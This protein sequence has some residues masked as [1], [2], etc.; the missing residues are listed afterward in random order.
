MVDHDPQ[1]LS[2]EANFRTVAA[3]RRACAWLYENDNGVV[4]PHFD[5]LDLEMQ[6]LMTAGARFALMHCDADA[7]L[8][9]QLNG[10]RIRMP[11]Q[12]VT[13]N[14]SSVWMGPGGLE[15]VESASSLAILQ[16]VVSP[17]SLLI[18]VGCGH[19][20]RSLA[21]AQATGCRTVAYDRSMA[22]VRMLKEIASLSA[23]Q[24]LLVEWRVL[25]PEVAQAST[26]DS[27]GGPGA[28]EEPLAPPTMTTLDAVLPVLDHDRQDRLVIYIGA[29]E[30]AGVLAGAQATLSELS[31]LL[32][33]PDLG[34]ATEEARGELW[35][36]GYRM[37][38]RGDHVL[39]LRARSA[40]RP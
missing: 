10:R 29:P 35:R 23:V 26:D 34:A 30:Q 25:G 7:I 40:A 3:M 21:L 1:A 8:S 5:T 22:S 33:M 13:D 14:M 16:E 19:G 37:E 2:L 11:I 4:D 32:V 38:A 27:L 39:A 28:H 36:L 9:L 24:N 20:F 15:I 12:A 6:K 17:R 31:P 18:D